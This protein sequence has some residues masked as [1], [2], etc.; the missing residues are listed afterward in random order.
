MTLPP[1]LQRGETYTGEDAYVT[2]TSFPNGRV[3]PAAWNLTWQPNFLAQSQHDPAE[4]LYH[5]TLHIWFRSY[6]QCSAVYLEPQPQ[7]PSFTNPTATATIN[8]TLYTWD[9]THLYAG[10]DGYEHLQVHNQIVQAYGSDTTGAL[11]TA[12]TMGI[13]PMHDTTTAAQIAA[14]P[15]LTTSSGS[16]VVPVPPSTSSCT[17]LCELSLS[18]SRRTPASTPTATPTPAPNFLMSPDVDLYVVS[19]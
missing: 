3:N 5:E 13:S 7:F 19:G 15:G 9:R 1:K 2:S 18:H 11:I 16:F 17:P 14:S 12:L 8:G 4:V 10:Y 6:H